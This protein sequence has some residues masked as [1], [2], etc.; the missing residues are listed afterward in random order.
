MQTMNNLTLFWKIP[1]VGGKGG[2][3]R[4]AKTWG[5]VILTIWTFFK[6]KHSFLWILN[7]KLKSAWPVCSKSMKLRQKWYR[8]NEYSWR[9]RFYWVITWKLLFSWGEFTFVER[10]E[11]IIWWGGTLPSPSRENPE[12]YNIW[13]RFINFNCP[14]NHQKTVAE[15]HRFSDGCRGMS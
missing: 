4:V 11:I 14:W 1:P 15:N 6:T 8:S 13:N 2:G 3:V 10:T 12:Y 5:G 9:W 7:I